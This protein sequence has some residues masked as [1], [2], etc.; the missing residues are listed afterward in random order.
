MDRDIETVARALCGFYKLDPE[1]WV[2]AGWHAA[3]TRSERM[4]SKSDVYLDSMSGMHRWQTF[5][6]EAEIILAHRFALTA[7]KEKRDVE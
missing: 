6:G 2:M 1:E 3:E 7:L 4:A 5:R